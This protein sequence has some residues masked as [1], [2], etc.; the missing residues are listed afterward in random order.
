MEFLSPFLNKNISHFKK[1]KKR[2]VEMHLY[3]KTTYAF[4]EFYLQASPGS[5]SVP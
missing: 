4:S 5:S 2:T 3:F 1:K